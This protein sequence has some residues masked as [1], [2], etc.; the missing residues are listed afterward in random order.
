MRFKKP[1]G[2]V[3]LLLV[4]GLLV[5]AVPT[6]ASTHRPADPAGTSS[7]I[8]ALSDWIAAWLTGPGSVNT[9]ASAPAWAAD[10]VGTATERNPE[11][12]AGAADD[13]TA[14]PQLGSD[15]DPDG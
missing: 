10:K 3:F 6:A 1:G 5:A 9:P 11:S 13:P 14:S 15:I 12:P 8:Q 2:I 7:L 4:L